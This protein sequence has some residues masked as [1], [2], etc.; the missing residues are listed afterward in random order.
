MQSL[1]GQARQQPLRHSAGGQSLYQLGTAAVQPAS[2]VAFV[3]PQG[4]GEEGGAIY[5][6]LRGCGGAGGPQTRR[7]HSGLRSYP[8][9][10]DSRD[11]R[12]HLLQRRRL[13]RELHVA[14]RGHE[15]TAALDRMAEVAR[16]NRNSAD[17]TAGEPSGMNRALLNASGPRAKSAMNKYPVPW[18]M[19]W[20]ARLKTVAEVTAASGEFCFRVVRAHSVLSA[21]GAVRGQGAVQSPDPT[22]AQ[23]AVRR[24]RA[25]QSPDPTSA[26]SAVRR[27]GTVQSPD[28]T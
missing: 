16:A 4:E 20:H 24:Q 23:S 6:Q 9:C 10:R 28:P 25:V 17:G 27:Q 3:I 11:R 12:H 1:A 15:R 18:N 21:H 2:L 14:G 7:R 13:G 8:P 5:R 22:S 19:P 26:Q